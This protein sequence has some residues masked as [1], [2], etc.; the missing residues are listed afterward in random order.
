MYFGSPWQRPH[1]SATLS[2][3]TLDRG[4]EG[5]LIEWAGWQ[6]T[7]GATFGS[8]AA[9]GPRPG[10]APE[11]LGRMDVLAELL[12]GIREALV[13]RL[14]IAGRAALG[15]LLLGRC[16]RGQGGDPH[17]S[18]PRESDESP[19]ARHRGR[20]WAWRKATRSAISSGRG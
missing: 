15:P 7:Q 3:W 5:G 9:P 11:S 18:E 20:P 6:F 14:E 12:H 8:P 13:S 2:G 16:G 1:V 19:H 4:S 17:E 10:P